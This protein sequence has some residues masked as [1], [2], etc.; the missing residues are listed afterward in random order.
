MRILHAAL[1]P[2]WERARRDGSYVA[3]TRGRTL[4]QEGFIHASTTAQASV[5]L[6]TF[7]ADVPG[8]VLLVLDVE[9][10][11]R[12]GSPVRWDDVPGAAGPFPHIYGPIP[13]TV[14]GQCGSAGR[15]PVVARLPVGHAI[16]EP[17]ELPDLTSYD[18]AT[19][20]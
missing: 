20:P 9:A 8:V 4:A 3:S 1:G 13:M 14:A 10:L 5:V 16:G 17:W 7:Y 2:D 11:G 12:A 18:I 6:D 19:G 15:A